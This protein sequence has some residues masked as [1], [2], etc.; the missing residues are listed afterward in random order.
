MW[1]WL[2]QHGGTPVYMVLNVNVS[3]WLFT[4]PLSP[5]REHPKHWCGLCRGQ[6][7]QSLVGPVHSVRPQGLL[8]MCIV[9]GPV[10]VRQKSPWSCG[11]Q[12]PKRKAS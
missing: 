5:F 2:G 9:P 1:C 12:V 7:T 10:P 8:S 4:G 11:M 3:Y 6:E